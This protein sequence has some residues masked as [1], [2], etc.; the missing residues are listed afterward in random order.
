[1]GRY[2]YRNMAVLVCQ[3]RNKEVRAG[4]LAAARRRG[5]GVTRVCVLDPAR[6]HAYTAI[7]GYDVL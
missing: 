4:H 6:L 7:V 5:D 1:M 2:P 3:R